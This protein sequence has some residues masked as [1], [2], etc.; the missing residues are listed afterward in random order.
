MRGD[1]PLP[2]QSSDGHVAWRKSPP[3]D[4]LHSFRLVRNPPRAGQA[5]PRALDPGVAQ[6]NSDAGGEWI[7]TP[8][9]KPRSPRPERRCAASGQTDKLARWRC[10]FMIGTSGSTT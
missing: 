1:P 10:A 6:R 2:T 7:G 9:P 5:C 8:P 3:H 4:P